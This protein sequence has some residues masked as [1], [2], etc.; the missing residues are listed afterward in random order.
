MAD[1]SRLP[2]QNSTQDEKLELELVDMAVHLGLKSVT[3]SNQLTEAQMWIIEKAL[4]APLPDG[5]TEHEDGQG[6][7]YY[8]HTSAQ[9][10]SWDHPMDEQ[11]RA[12]IAGTAGQRSSDK[13]DQS[14]LQAALNSA[15]KPT[16][17]P[18]EVFAS[19]PVEGCPA[20]SARGGRSTAGRA[21]ERLPHGTRLVTDARQEQARRAAAHTPDILNPILV[22][23]AVRKVKDALGADDLRAGKV[24]EVAEALEI[25]CM[26]EPGLLWI[27]EQG[28]DAPMP[29]GWAMASAGKLPVYVHGESGT[30]IN[31]HPLFPQLR[32]LAAKMR[33]E[34]YAAMKQGKH[35]AGGE[36]NRHPRRRRFSDSDGLDESRK[37]LGDTFESS[38]NFSDTWSDGEDDDGALVAEYRGKLWSRQTPTQPEDIE[39]SARKPTLGET[40]AKADG[41]IGRLGSTLQEAS[42]SAARLTKSLSLDRPSTALPVG[43]C[44]LGT[45]PKS[46]SKLLERGTSAVSRSFSAARTSTRR[47]REEVYRVDSAMEQTA[48][49]FGFAQSATPSSSAPGTEGT[50]RLPL[51]ASSGTLPTFPSQAGEAEDEGRRPVFLMQNSRV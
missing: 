14:K 39:R 36:G 28:V 12:M 35:A 4:E 41:L 29:E 23:K 26:Q 33:A 10:S 21:P 48:P 20:E 9:Q 42:N 17:Q 31:E 43:V 27:A 30:V 22:A 50:A 49:S 5:W 44:S 38:G 11:F 37:S 18:R 3:A 40:F 25:S 7:V 51:R 19:P 32:K 6:R 45:L 24:V 2:Q 34:A 16:P 1:T 47:R 13:C 15:L 46:R 8:Y